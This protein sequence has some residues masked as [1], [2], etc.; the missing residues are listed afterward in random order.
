M[1]R[2]LPHKCEH[3]V[4]SL[5]IFSG[6]CITFPSGRHLYPSNSNSSTKGILNFSPLLPT[7][8]SSLTSSSNVLVHHRD[9]CF[10]SCLNPSAPGEV[11]S[12]FAVQKFSAQNMHDSLGSSSLS[13]PNQTPRPLA[14]HVSYTLQ[15]RL[16]G[17]HPPQNWT[18]HV[19]LSC[20]NCA[21]LF[22]KHADPCTSLILHGCR[23]V[24]VNT[25]ECQIPLTPLL[26]A[27]GRTPS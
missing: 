5:R 19:R 24:S 27:P 22:S 11:A 3:P 10:D 1:R 25:C 15:S 20:R 2:S 18:L 17:H 16:L 23:H 7:H 14:L 21:A 12:V 8:V 26:I 9:S 13:P 6:T 4:H